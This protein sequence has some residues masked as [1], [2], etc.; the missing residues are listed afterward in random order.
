MIK[1]PMIYVAGP[2]TVGPHPLNIRNGIDVGKTLRE[3]GMIPFIPMV[4][5]LYMVVY[6][7]TTWE[8]NLDYDEQIILRCDAL[9]R[10]P[11]ESKGADR[12]VEFARSNGIPVFFDIASLHEWTQLNAQKVNTD[13]GRIGCLCSGR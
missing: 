3:L 5:F 1:K 7:H 4:D 2:I 12:E 10:I 13:C 11:G 8:E 6:P 9:L